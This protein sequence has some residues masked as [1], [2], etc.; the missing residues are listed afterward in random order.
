M[1]LTPQQTAELAMHVKTLR[2]TVDLMENVTPECLY[3]TIN[4]LDRNGILNR[5]SVALLSL[6][7]AVIG[8]SANSEPINVVYLK[9]GKDVTKN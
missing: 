7:L 6:R 4:I 1:K 5:A 8:E 9:R 3:E 2:D